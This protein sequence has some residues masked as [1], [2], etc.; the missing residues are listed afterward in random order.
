MP[1]QETTGGTKQET[2]TGTDVTH[3]ADCWYG[4]TDMLHCFV[5]MSDLPLQGELEI[6]K[7][8]YTWLNK[9]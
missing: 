9:K 8:K 1:A 5:L 7:E 4:A 3:P 6:D 2:M